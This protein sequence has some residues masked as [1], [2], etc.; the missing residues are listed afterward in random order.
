MA[1]AIG[2]DRVTAQCLI[3]R[4]VHDPGAAR[5][6]LQ[7]SLS[8]LLRPEDLPDV[9]A[10]VARIRAAIRARETIC[11]WGDYDVDGV[12][13]TAI[14]V[15]FLRQLGA[16]RVVPFIPERTGSGYG[17]HWPTMERLA[18]DTG[19]SLFVSVDHGSTAVEAVTTA[20]EH[21]LDVVVADHHEIAPTLPPAVAIVNPKRA[22]S[23]YG[24]PHLCGAGVAM[25]LAWAVAQE[26]SPG[27]RVTDDMREFLMDALGNA[28]L[29]T[30]ADVVP[31]VGENRIIVRHG[32]AVL[33]SR[34]SPGIRALLD[35]SGARAP[36]RAS[37]VGF[38]LGPRLNA[39]GRMGSAHLALELLLT[40]D[41]VRAREIAE[42]LDRANEQRRAVERE[43]AEAALEIARRDYGARPAGGIAL[44]GESWHHGV[45]G[46]VA[47]RLVDTFHVPVVLVS[48]ADGV[49]R[50]SARSVPGF[51]L[52]EALEACSEHLVS[53]GG[54]AAAAG[55]TIRP[56]RFDGFRA[57]FQRY[58]EQH[59]PEDARVPELAIDAEV[60][61]HDL[62]AAVAA[63]LA[64]LEP[65]G[66]GNPEPVLALRGLQ[67]V[68]RPRRMG[69]RSDHVAFHLAREGRSVRCVAFRQADAL[70]PLLDS[71]RALDVALTPQLNTFRGAA[72]VEGLV[73]DLRP[74]EA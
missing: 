57:A 64:R 11:V 49:G 74:A 69:A 17:F 21:G 16:A 37:D 29:G 31:L 46:I 27:A 67:V 33:Q 62:D 2:L 9:A 63:G 24:F 40:D 65:F 51:A 34:G 44:H 73:R 22:D 25:K 18:R 42:Q 70:Q 60:G 47:S 35:V 43:V 10:A 48:T 28:V 52:H 4:G 12:S 66:A 36:L 8:D 5:A 15:R 56:E 13:G 68:G 7:G 54:H 19:V 71:G 38:K 3:N 53:H 45:I 39:A 61:V 26:M 59:L 58:V 6:H 20:R 50:G 55:L 1:R 14:L 23:A 30:V 41:P 32:L 72:D